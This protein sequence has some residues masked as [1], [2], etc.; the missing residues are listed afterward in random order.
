ME[1]A[2]FLFP[3]QGAQAVGMAKDLYEAHPR[4]REVFQRAGDQVDFDLAALCFEGPDDRLQLTQYSQPCILVAS[5]ALLEVAR[6]ETRLQAVTP[7][8]AAGLSLGEYTALVF[9]GCLRFE[10]AVRLVYRRG[11]AMAAAGEK[12]KGSMLAVVGLT[13]AQLG[14]ITAKASAQGVVV[15]ANYNSP[16]QI[17]LSGEPAAL[18]EA[19]RLAKE[20]GARMTVE[21]KV[22][23]AFHSPLMKP[24]ADELT[25]ALAEVEIARPQ[26]PVVSNVTA[27]YLTHP[28]QVRELLVRQLTS[29]VKW[30]QSMQKLIDD[31]VNAFYEIG[32]GRVLGG[33]MKRIDRTAAVTSV[34][35]LDAL[36][37]LGE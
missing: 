9:A 15:A 27:D 6:N 14:E 16:D 5:I 30:C 21:L 19:G 37:A 26:V 11:Q 10:D 24:A 18:A 8:A 32:P 34:N 2:A 31:G 29:P 17:V 4:A 3:G 1:R 23:G 25:A 33:F 22:S 20:A 7:L 36:K 28:D 12:R 35:A 13:E